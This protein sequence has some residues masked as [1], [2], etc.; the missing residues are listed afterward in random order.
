MGLQPGIDVLVMTCMLKPHVKDSMCFL[1][2]ER[3][4]DLFAGI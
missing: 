4:V 3:V 2:A 1:A